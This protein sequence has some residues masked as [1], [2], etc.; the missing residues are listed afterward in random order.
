MA[1]IPSTQQNRYFGWIVNEDGSCVLEAVA[2]SGKTTTLI[3]GLK[4]MSG[5]IFFGAFNKAIALEITEKVA[6]LCLSNV[7]VSTI[8]AAGFAIWRKVAR[9]VVVDNNKCRD[10]FRK[11]AGYDKETHKLCN[12]V[13]SL[14]SYAKQAALGY[15]SDDIFAA[16]KSN[17]A[18]EQMIDHYNVDCLEREIE[19]IALAKEV[20]LKSNMSVCEL[21]D[22][23]D[24]I[25][26]PLINKTKCPKYDWVLIDEAQD[27]N[28]SRRAL[29][30]M[31]L[32]EGGRLVA[33]GDRHQAIYGFTGAD[34][35]A[36]DIIAKEVS[37]IQIPLT[38]SYRC[39]KSI[40]T[41]A[42]NFV[43]HI[44]AH[45]SAIEGIV[46]HLN[47]HDDITQIAKVGDAILCRFNAPIVELVYKFIAAGIPAK[48][49]GREIGNNLKALAKRWKI[50]TLNALENKLSEYR[51]REVKKAR[52]KEEEG[53]VV[54]IQDKVTC[55]FILINRVRSIN[56][57]A[58]I[59]TLCTEIDNIF[60][61]NVDNAKVLLSTI[62]KSK[63]REWK[64]V[65]WIQGSATWAKKDWE[66]QCEKNLSYVAITRSQEHL[67]FV[68]APAKE[69][70]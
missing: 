32:K 27:T 60:E 4:L 52:L 3:E 17:T 70:H 33:V 34:S 12:A 48:L 25:Y 36:L 43:S 31:M 55:M 46:S 59:E 47:D 49:E 2:G 37:A 66:K 41:E 26:A 29:A 54:A 67:I 15:D 7:S 9:N 38:V 23:D 51:D 16:I 64:K 35:D 57:S 69:K 8:H 28:A 22:F 20:L 40:V 39:P 19:V 44:E 6:K 65:F 50:V 14:V 61:N 5:D 1:F 53:K 10:I 58:T 63:G 24:M 11:I 62:H 45:E 56:P 13:L 30:L 18:W 21:V 68:P 42:Q